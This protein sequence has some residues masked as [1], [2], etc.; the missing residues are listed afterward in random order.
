MA[1]FRILIIV[2]SCIS[3]SNKNNCAE[4][5][6]GT[7]DLNDPS[8]GVHT[9]IERDEMFQFET[10]LANGNETKCS[11]TWID[12]C[13]YVLKYL[14]TESERL[15]P[16]IGHELIIEITKTDDRKVFFS[17]VMKTS[18]KKSIYMM[19]KIDE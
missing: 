9:R 4:Y 12:D 16:L 8:I 10:N 19:T 18:G 7:F 13:T 11:I 17:P 6:T 14:E 3:S 1:L 15:K 5:Q 2:M